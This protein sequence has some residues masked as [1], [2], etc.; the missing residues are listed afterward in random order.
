M[1]IREQVIEIIQLH[2]S[3]S[4]NSSAE[5]KG[6]TFRNKTFSYDTYGYATDGGQ[7]MPEVE[8]RDEPVITV[9]NISVWER[10]DWVLDGPWEEKA[11]SIIAEYLEILN[12]EKEKRRLD[13]ECAAEAKN[14]EKQNAR[15]LARQ[16]KT[17]AAIKAFNKAN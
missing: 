11:D 1:S 7:G 16:L 17:E 6:L 9:S 12:N 13:E 8:E 15:N 10:H 5:H 2:K 14:K 4:P 3:L